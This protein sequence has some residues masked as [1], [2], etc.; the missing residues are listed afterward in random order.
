MGEYSYLCSFL[1][2]YQ[3]AEKLLALL[4]NKILPDSFFFF[5]TLNCI[6]ILLGCWINNCSLLLKDKQMVAYCV[7]GPFLEE[8]LYCAAAFPH[9]SCNAG[10]ANI[11]YK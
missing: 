9:A 1:S 7:I 6:L 5:F 3:L 2:P 11:S 10:Y 4:L 8:N